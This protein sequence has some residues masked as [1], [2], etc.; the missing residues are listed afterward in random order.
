MSAGGPLALIVDARFLLLHK[1]DI[2]GLKLDKTDKTNID[3]EGRARPE[4]RKRVERHTATHST[5][6]EWGG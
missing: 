1:T 4:T 6:L 2:V 5:P 3:Q